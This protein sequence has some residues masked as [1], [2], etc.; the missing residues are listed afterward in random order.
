[1]SDTRRTV[2]QL[3]AGL[4]AGDPQHI[5]DCFVPE[6]IDWYIPGAASRGQRP[7]DST[8]AWYSA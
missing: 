7:S 5:A 3:L 2:E 1:M 8:S 4:G 6:A